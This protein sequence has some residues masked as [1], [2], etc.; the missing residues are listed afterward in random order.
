VQATEFRPTERWVSTD[1][2]R[3]VCVAAR[4]MGLSAA[5]IGDVIHQIASDASF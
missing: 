3:R 5:Y 2:L 1:F 4:E